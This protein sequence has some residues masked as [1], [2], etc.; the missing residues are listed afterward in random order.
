MIT[1]LIRA[2]EISLKAGK[3]GSEKLRNREK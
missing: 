2:E 3:T 1:V